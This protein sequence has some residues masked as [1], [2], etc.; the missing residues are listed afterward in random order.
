MYASL[1]S[2]AMRTAIDETKRRRE[3]QIKYNKEH[4]IVPK[5]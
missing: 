2:D 3:I 5:Q 4:N 1:I